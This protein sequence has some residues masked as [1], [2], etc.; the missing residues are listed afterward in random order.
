MSCSRVHRSPQHLPLFRVWDE[1]IILV[2]LAKL[3]EVQIKV[4][5]DV[6][7]ADGGTRTASISGAYV[8]LQLAFRHLTQIGMLKES[9]MTGQLAAISCGIC[10]KCCKELQDFPSGVP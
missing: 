2:D 1:Q 10:E 6:I 4:D 5:C 7:Q 9:P 8:A 3:P